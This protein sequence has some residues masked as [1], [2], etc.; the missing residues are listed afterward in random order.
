MKQNSVI[1][2]ASNLKSDMEETNSR[3]RNLEEE[4]TCMRKK[5]NGSIKEKENKSDSVTAEGEFSDKLSVEFWRI[6]NVII[7]TIICDADHQ[8]KYPLVVLGS[9]GVAKGTWVLL[10]KKRI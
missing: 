6:L 2:Q 1:G 3:L 4:I 8:R 10:V 5:I 9:E 7:S